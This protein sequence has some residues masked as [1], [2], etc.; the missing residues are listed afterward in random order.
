MSEPSFRTD[1]SVAIS[2]D[3]KDAES[4]HWRNKKLYGR[5]KE[6]S[7]LLLAYRK[8]TEQGEGPGFVCLAGAEGTGKTALALTLRGPVTDDGGYF[9]RG[10]FDRLLRAE[11]FAAFVSAFQELTTL[12]VSRGEKTVKSMR[13]DIHSAIAEESKILIDTIPSLE[14]IIGN[15]NE[16][17]RLQ[18]AQARLRFA[19]VFRKFVRAVCFQKK[20]L[21]L[22]LDDLHFADQSSLDLLA[23]LISDTS[24]KGILFVATYKETGAT[25]PV[26]K[27]LGRLEDANV[28]ICR[29]GL[30][31][32][33]DET[34]KSMVVDILA[35]P[36]PN[37]KQ[38]TDFI[39][40][41]TAGNVL[42]VIEFLCSL[43][44]KFLLR[45]DSDEKRWVVNEQRV[46]Q[47]MGNN[48]VGDLILERMKKQAQQLLDILKVASCLGSKLDE[49]LLHCA[50]SETASKFL[51]DGAERGFLTYNWEQDN[52]SFTHDV[53]QQAAYMLTPKEHRSAFHLAIGRKLRKN[54]SPK[55]LDRNIY[56]VLTQFRVGVD[57]VTSHRERYDIAELCLRA[58]E[59]AVS[60]SS[61]PTASLYV[62][63]G[64]EVLGD[65]HWKDA[66]ALSLELYNTGT[67]VNYCTANFE[68][69]R[70]LLSTL[71]KNARSFQ[72]KLRAYAT[73]VY[74]LGATDQMGEAI[75]RGL[76][77]LGELGEPIAPHASARRVSSE[78]D[79][80]QRLTRG[81]TDESL[82]RLPLMTDPD[83]LAAMKMLNLIFLSAMM[84]RPLLAATVSLSMM[85]LTLKHGLSA[86]S[87]TAFV[88]YGMLLCGLPVDFDQG[89]RFGQLSLT[90][91]ERFKM[92]EWLPRVYAGVYGVINL[93][94][95]PVWLTLEPLKTGFTIGLEFG[96]IEYAMLNANLYC[97]N[98]I[99]A[100]RSLPFIES[101]L[102]N[103][104]EIMTIQKQE[105]ALVMV[106]PF[107]RFIQ[108]L[109]GLSHDLVSPTGQLSFYQTDALSH[110]VETENSMSVFAI[111]FQGLVLAYLFGDYE[112]ASRMA[113]NCR[114]LLQNP[115]IGCDKCSLAFYDSLVALALAAESQAKEKARH[116]ALARR[117]MKIL[118]NWARE[119]PHNCLARLSLVQAEEA[120]V[121]GNRNRAYAKYL[122]AIAVAHEEGLL[123]EH[124]MATERMGRHLIRLN[125][126]SLAAPYLQ[127]SHVLYLEWGASA[128]AKYLKDEFNEYITES[129]PQSI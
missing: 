15:Q 51:D 1:D 58:A 59:K 97:F 102:T 61:F 50:L 83:K 18:G 74:V 86:M 94:K 87:S 80:M 21:V 98:L 30:S 104:C 103:F 110:A 35:L 48:L 19:F 101:E 13:H 71:F 122:I 60:A 64:I 108:N 120:S 81:K 20:P 92:K 107:I 105:S 69:V 9:I 3:H 88:T 62:D 128:K 24:N 125:D 14:Q 119:S 63:F 42:F 127:R 37:T 106:R 73:E 82:L 118:K 7:T 111:N 72:D 114:P 25:S 113:V 6:G 53:F 26:S 45:F 96:D 93:H 10:K 33:H 16:T 43:E 23:S 8:T 29:V 121:T 54:L 46:Y 27:L 84:T 28:P 31:N 66:Y 65:N 77:V 57:E 91:L 47:E 11:P 22:L 116:I 95:Q 4:F 5:A 36:P 44:D 90:L 129:G 56:V 124:S 115:V 117:N 79:K 55:E 41:Q 112:L 75:S 100:G 68:R 67:E 32:F 12:V 17:A 76:K 49:P 89:Y 126:V 78:V 99:N 52:Y 34:V 38:L 85:R 2:V 109:T 39:Y 40:N 70:D 123:N